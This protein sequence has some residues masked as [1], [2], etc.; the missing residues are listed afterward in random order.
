VSVATSGLAGNGSSGVSAPPRISNDGR[1][2]LFSSNASDLVAGDANLTPDLFVRD[3]VAGTTE[4]VSI[5]TGGVQSDFAPSLSFVMDMTPDG[6]FVSW[7]T[8]ASNLVLGDTNGVEDV[9]VRDRLLGTTERRSV[10][11]S[12]AQGDSPSVGGTLSDDGRRCAFHSLATNLVGGDTNAVMDAFLRDT[13]PSAFTGTCDPGAGGVIACPC[14]NAPPGP[15]RGCDNSASTGGASLS[16]SGAAYLSLDSLV[17]QTSGEKPTAT[18]VLLQGTTSLS[19]GAVY[20]QGVRCLGGALKRLFTKT[21]SGGSITAPEFGFGDPTVSSRSAAKGDAI[22]AGE[23]RWYLVFYRDPI[24]LG[25]CSA[26]S[27]F[28]ATQTGRVIW[29]Y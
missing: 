16:A 23:S 14:A 22:Q 20:G 18:S 13:D 5:S 6:R 8:K 28:N 11:T 10:G 3:L 15:G 26:T 25:G 24:V 19:S 7:S 2:V 27:T 1:Y 21:A 4:L 12:G 9:F 17:F 29:S